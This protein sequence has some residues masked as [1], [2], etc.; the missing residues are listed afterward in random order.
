MEVHFKCL[1]EDYWKITKNAYVVPQSGLSTPDGVKE[2]KYNIRAKEELLSALTDSEMTNVMELHTTHEI[3]EK[4][5]ILSIGVKIE[6]DEIVDKVLRSFPPSYKHKKYDLD[7]CKISNY[8]RERKEIAEQERELDDLDTLIS[9][10]L[11]KGVGMYDGK[12]PLKCFSYNKIGHFS[13][14]CLER[15][16][17]YDR[18]D[19]FDKPDRNDRYEKHEK[20]DKTYKFNRKF[21]NQKN[22]YYA[23]DE[24]VTY[25]E[26]EGDEVVFISIKEDRPVPIDSTSF[27]IEEK[28]L[29]IKVEEKGEWV[30]DNSCSHHITGDKRKLV[31]IERYDGGIVIFGDDKACVIHGRGSISFNGKYNIDDVLYVEGFKHKLLSVG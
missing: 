12:F 24:G 29:A 14:R 26:L 9:Q 21:R 7:E 18:H 10:R 3:W 28:T 8:E 6:E 22:Y 27:S 17:K 4:L 23:I 31:R 19:K 25:D 2:V 30:I 20:F 1:G 13:S 11:P 16:T 5:E 15:K